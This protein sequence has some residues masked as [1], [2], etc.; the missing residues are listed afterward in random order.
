[1]SDIDP[2]TID[3]L[4][5]LRVMVEKLQ[6]YTRIQDLDF[7]QRVS[8]EVEERIRAERKSIWSEGFDEG[9]DA[10]TEAANK[11]FNKHITEVRERIDEA[12]DIHLSDYTA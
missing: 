11:D 5:A 3:D 4:D 7:E 6:A 10:G 8:T 1:M 2:N 9:H 12:L